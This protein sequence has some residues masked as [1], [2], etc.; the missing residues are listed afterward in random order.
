MN[1]INN[2]ALQVTVRNIYII[3]LLFL[4]AQVF[5]GPKTDTVYLF[6]GDRITGEVKRMEFGVLFFKA[7][8]M[9][10]LQIE[11]DRIKTFYSSQEFTLQLVNGLRFFGSIDTSSLDGHINLVVNNF[12]IPEPINAVVEVFPIKNAFWQRLDGAVDLGYSY[13]KASSLSQLNFSGHLDYRVQ[14]SFSQA[15]ASSIYTDQQDRDRIRK[16]DYSLSHNRFFRKKWFAGALLGAQQ[17][18][19]LGNSQRFFGGLGIGNDIVHNNSHVLTAI[20]G[21]LVSTETSSADSLL[22]SVEGMVQISY[23]VFRFNNPEV[24]LNSYYN[25]YPSFTTWG[26]VRMEFELKAQIELFSDFYF[27]VSFYDNFDNM[28]VDGGPAVNDWGFSTSIGYSW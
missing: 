17:N 15:K 12:R 24:E 4:S 22:K 3:F 28:P 19:E 7:D 27:G 13:T 20:G 26:R 23:K 21:A 14:K 2:K 5:A 25:V 18:T 10:T 16:Q 8:G 9:G 6:N 1:L 11:Y